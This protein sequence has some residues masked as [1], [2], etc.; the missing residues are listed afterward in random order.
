[1]SP[2][3]RKF[4]KFTLF[5][6]AVFCEETCVLFDIKGFLRIQ[7]LSL[8]PKSTS[9]HSLTNFLDFGSILRPSLRLLVHLEAKSS[10]FQLFIMMNFYLTD[11]DNEIALL[12][13]FSSFLETSRDFY[14][15]KSIC[16][17]FLNTPKASEGHFQSFPRL[18]KQKFANLMK[19]RENAT[20]VYCCLS[21]NSASLFW[22][23]AFKM[24]A[25]EFEQMKIK[26]I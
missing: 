11:G 25:S 21:K 5:F 15:S 22:F 9:K 26:A 20:F 17:W 2:K 24:G 14:H 3:K 23:S 12:T 18:H 19:I 7:E 13:N 4:R 1:M 16:Q 8:T 10:L 6:T